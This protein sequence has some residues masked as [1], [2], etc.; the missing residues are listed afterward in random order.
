IQ[1]VSRVLKDK[2][3]DRLADR[4]IE[5]QEQEDTTIPAMQRQLQECEKGIENML[6]AIQMGIL[7]SSTKE[8]L[9]QLEAQRDELK[10][11]ILQAQLE[12]P[13]YTKEQI[14]RWISRFKYGNPDDPEY[15]RQIVDTFV[16][17]VYVYD[18][19]L[20]FTY[21]FKDGTETIS[22]KEIEEAF[23][24]DLS[25]CA[26]PQILHFD[27]GFFLLSTCFCKFASRKL[28][29]CKRCKRFDHNSKEN[30]H[31]F[32]DITLRFHRRVRVELRSQ[33]NLGVTKDL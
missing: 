2:E 30:I 31:L 17:A 22:K 10:T 7:T 12:R 19:R 4:I 24:S 29:A 16:N 23:S 11:A 8:R 1:T 25:E 32:H 26:P 20:V 3:I 15:R 6:N 33:R 9:E 18:D 28:Q 13:K 27:A 5:L 14:V 21:N